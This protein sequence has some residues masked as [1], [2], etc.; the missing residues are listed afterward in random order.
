[1]RRDEMGYSVVPNKE[2]KEPG[3]VLRYRLLGGKAK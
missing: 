3:N 2:L 1:M